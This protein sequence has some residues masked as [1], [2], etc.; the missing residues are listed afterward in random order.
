MKMVV[1]T[2]TQN[3]TQTHQTFVG[4]NS[5]PTWETWHRCFGHVRYTGLQK[6]L[7]RKMVDGFIVDE[8]SPKP[9]CIACMEAKQRVEPFP[10]LSKRNTKPSELTHIDLWGKYLIRLIN[11]HQ[12]YLLFVDNAIRFATIECVRQKSDAAQGVINYLAHVETQGQ[13]LKRIQIDCGKEFINDMLESWCK[14]R[15]TEIHFTTPYSPSQNGIA[16]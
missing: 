8:H 10:K 13:N 12:Y 9:D 4:K 2:P 7:D 16:E 1:R 11:G 3:I 5:L 15:S 6:L 14:E